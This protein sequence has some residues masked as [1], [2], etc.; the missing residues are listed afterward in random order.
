MPLSTGSLTNVSVASEPEMSAIKDPGEEG[1]KPTTDS[2]NGVDS[3][4]RH[5]FYD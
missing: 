5:Y 3:T 2:A 4:V 1:S